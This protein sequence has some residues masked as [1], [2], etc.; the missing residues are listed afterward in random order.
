VAVLVDNGAVSRLTVRVADLLKS[1]VDQAAARDGTSVNAWITR[2][3]ADAVAG[4][5]PGPGRDDP[6][7]RAEP[8]PRPTF[9]AHFPFGPAGAPAGASRG[10]P[11]DPRAPPSVPV[12][13][14]RSTFAAS[15]PE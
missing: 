9:G 4:G 10:G 1:Q 7:P 11:G 2:V 12:D 13:P 15:R 14:A 3:L 5:G 8:G 6:G